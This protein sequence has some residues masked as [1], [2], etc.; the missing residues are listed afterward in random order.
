MF[1]I[2]C[3]LFVVSMVGADEEKSTPYCVTPADCVKLIGAECNEPGVTCWCVEQ[4]SC[5]L[6]RA[7]DP[8]KNDADCN[9]SAPSCILDESDNSHFCGHKLYGLLP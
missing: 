4:T 8:A 5:S 3:F 1:L 2:L 6:K 9:E 7:C